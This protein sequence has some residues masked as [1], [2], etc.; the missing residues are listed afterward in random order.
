MN[1]PSPDFFITLNE[2][3]EISGYGQGTCS[4]MGESTMNYVT[5][6][7]F[8]ACRY[9]EE[10]KSWNI[11][12]FRLITL[13][14]TKKQNYNLSAIQ[15]HTQS[16][17][18]LFNKPDFHPPSIKTALPDLYYGGH[19]TDLD[20]GYMQSEWNCTFEEFEKILEYFFQ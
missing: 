6:F 10:Y 9:E 16:Y 4:T 12:K 2:S 3:F 1:L 5:V 20:I 13:F 19:R 14:E 8:V 15:A 17:R 11:F 7:G 18:T